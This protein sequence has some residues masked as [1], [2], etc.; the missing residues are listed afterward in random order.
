MNLFP[1]T[2]NYLTFR[3]Y[4]TAPWVVN[5]SLDP[6]EVHADYEG[7]KRYSLINQWRSPMLKERIS[8]KE[9]VFPY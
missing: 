3:I 4:D 2:R 1:S 9:V 5:F 7:P 6:K 8:D